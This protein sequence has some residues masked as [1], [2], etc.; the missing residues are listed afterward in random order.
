MVDHDTRITAC[1][2]HHSPLATR[3]SDHLP[4][5]ADVELAGNTR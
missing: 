4:V 5:W 3:A 2:V 1:G